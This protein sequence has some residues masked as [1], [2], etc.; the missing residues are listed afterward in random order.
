MSQLQEQC[1]RAQRGLQDAT[2]AQEAAEQQVDR[3]TQQLCSAET[4]R[5]QEDADARQQ[6]AQELARVS[7]ELR[8]EQ[9][10]NA[11]LQ[12]QNTSLSEQAQQSKADAT[13]SQAEAEG[14][15]IKC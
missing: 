7:A 1:F 9:Q 13:H 6:A 2:A 8:T 4:R 15:L 5:G 14:A 10:R 11:A 3:L 12:R